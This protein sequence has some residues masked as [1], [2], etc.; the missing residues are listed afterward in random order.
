V[1]LVELIVVLAILGLLLAMSG[2]ALASLR[3]PPEAAGIRELA[4]AHAEA[5]R[6]GAPVTG[7]SV[8]FLPDG[9]AIGAGVDYLTGGPSAR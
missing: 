5:I 6:G 4:R 8:L 1:T 3:E 9:R 2:L 7:D